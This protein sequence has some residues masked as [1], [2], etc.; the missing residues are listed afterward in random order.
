MHRL[1]QVGVMTDLMAYSRA[2]RG[3]H[4]QHGSYPLELEEATGSIDWYSPI[5]RWGTPIV[6]LSSGE[7]FVLASMGL[8]GQPDGEN[9]LA[10][11]ML[12]PR[13]QGAAAGEC[14]NPQVDQIITDRGWY[15]GCGK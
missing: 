8:G 1:R 3:Y 12:D 9:Y 2:L 10:V 13:L 14:S 4:E 7:G 5:D 15:R 11:R 6:Y